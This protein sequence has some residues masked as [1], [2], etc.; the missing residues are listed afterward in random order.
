MRV[1][2][3]QEGGFAG[4]ARPPLVVDSTQLAPE[5]QRELDRL[6]VECNFFQLP[7]DGPTPSEGAADYLTYILTV[8]REQQTHSIRVTDPVTDAAL[9][10]L[11]AFVKGRH[12]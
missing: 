6:I 4:L 10:A 9:A 5:Q 11:I 7:A 1:V 12:S 8:E 3:H 2:L